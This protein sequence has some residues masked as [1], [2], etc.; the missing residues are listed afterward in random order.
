MSLV[1]IA[2]K[3]CGRQMIFHDYFARQVCKRQWK[4]KVTAGKDQTD[5]RSYF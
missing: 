3:N 1:G 4:Q 2:C 5:I